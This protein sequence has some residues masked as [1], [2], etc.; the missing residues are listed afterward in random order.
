MARKILVMNSQRWA[1]NKQLLLDF[2]RALARKSLR[3]V[4]VDCSNAEVM[5]INA[6][7][8]RSSLDIVDHILNKCRLKQTLQQD[9]QPSL[10]IARLGSIDRLKAQNLSNEYI[11]TSISQLETIFDYCL[12]A[13]DDACPIPI[14]DNSYEYI[15]FTACTWQSVEQAQSILNVF[16]K[17]SL[18]QGVVALCSH[19]LGR[20]KDMDVNVFFEHILAVPLGTVHQLRGRLDQFARQ[21]IVD[22]CLDI[23]A[24]NIHNNTTDIVIGKGNRMVVKRYT[25]RYYYQ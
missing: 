20:Q 1:D 12:I 8:G 15:L 19:K 4:I 10:F 24:S 16:S 22:N 7:Y 6:P 23:V 18:M 13:Y 25:N 11:A 5:D 21:E 2:G 14:T 3:V 9:K 17:C